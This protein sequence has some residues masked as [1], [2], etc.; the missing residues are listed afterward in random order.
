[1]PEGLNVR[2]VDQFDLSAPEVRLEARTSPLQHGFVGHLGAQLDLGCC[3]G[4]TPVPE[5]IGPGLSAV[6]IVHC[7]EKDSHRFRNP[8]QSGCFI[9]GK[10]PAGAP[11]DDGNGLDDR[12]SRPH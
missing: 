8:L 7:C 1:V 6:S 12:I 9:R 5:A 3:N 11:I 10:R 4:H 2:R